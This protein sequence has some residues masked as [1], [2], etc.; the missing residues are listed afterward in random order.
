MGYFRDIW[1]HYGYRYSYRHYRKSWGEPE[2][3][4]YR[5]GIQPDKILVCLPPLD[6]PILEAV[7]TISWIPNYFPKAEIR[8]VHYEEVAGNI[9]IQ[10][11][12]WGVLEKQHFNSF[13]LPKRSFLEEIRRWSPDLAIDLSDPANEVTDLICAMSG[14]KW[15]AALLNN[16]GRRF[17]ST[18][19]ILISP[20]QNTSRQERYGVLLRYLAPDV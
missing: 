14:A 1:H 7:R 3:F 17:T 2:K 16:E 20:M 5:R 11:H 12:S 4:A 15:H 9:P 18:G 10:F 8:I 6:G 13:G 19:N